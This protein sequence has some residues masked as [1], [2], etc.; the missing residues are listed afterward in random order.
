MV[1][2]AGAR[3][4]WRWGRLG[5][6]TLILLLHLERRWGNSTSSSASLLVRVS[7]LPRSLYIIITVAI[8]QDLTM[9]SWSNLPLQQDSTALASPIGE[10]QDKTDVRQK[11]SF[12]FERQKG[13]Q[14]DKTSSMHLFKVW[15][16]KS[17]SPLMPRSS[18]R[19][20][21]W[22]TKVGMPTS[23]S[24]VVDSQKWSYSQCTL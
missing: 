1:A 14:D 5:P 3:H 24:W 9:V 20:C 10:I 8:D 15:I 16:V 11:F 22:Q 13:F 18:G 7:V 4:Y 2:G 12:S 6:P 23:T 19:G 21:V 17:A